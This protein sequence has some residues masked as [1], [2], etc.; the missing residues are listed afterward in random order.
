[1]VYERFTMIFDRLIT[2]AAGRVA[3][4]PGFILR[5]FSSGRSSATA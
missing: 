2:I 3:A 5:N 1:M 4:W